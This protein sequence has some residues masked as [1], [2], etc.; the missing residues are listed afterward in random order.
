M[1]NSKIRMVLPTGRMHETVLLLLEGAGLRLPSSQR[2][3]R[4]QASDHAFEVKL[5]RAANIPRER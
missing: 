4:P 2:N 1:A 3:Y 5:L